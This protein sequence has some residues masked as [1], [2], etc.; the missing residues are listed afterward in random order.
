M[1]ITINNSPCADRC[2]K[3]LKE[4]VTKHNLT[5]VTIHYMNPFGTNA[6][7]KAASDTLTGITLHPIDPAAEWPAAMAKV[8]EVDKRKFEAFRIKASPYMA[9]T[10]D[11]E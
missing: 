7:F 6:E 4:F 5:K 9:T 3:K 1:T 2:A 10:G 8:P 11:S